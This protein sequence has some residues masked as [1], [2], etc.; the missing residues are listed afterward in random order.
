MPTHFQPFVKALADVTRQVKPLIAQL[1]DD[2]GEAIG[3][4]GS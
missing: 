2:I 4:S 3:L 1:A